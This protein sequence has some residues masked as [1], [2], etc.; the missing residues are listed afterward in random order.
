[1][2][3]LGQRE[4]LFFLFFTLRHSD[5]SRWP[6]RLLPFSSPT[7]LLC[8]FVCVRSAVADWGAASGPTGSLGG[9]PL[10]PP[11]TLV[12]TETQPHYRGP[13]LPLPHSGH[14]PTEVEVV[15]TLTSAPS[16]PPVLDFPPLHKYSLDFPLTHFVSPGESNPVSICAS[17]A[18][19]WWARKLHGGP[20]GRP[21]PHICYKVEMVDNVI[22]YRGYFT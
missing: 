10:T 9:E 4:H 5:A 19:R 13:G 14:C 20:A 3:S 15:L 2:H 7:I 11:T 21:V 12:S 22:A 6:E 16:R 18:A 8:T 1:M 17:R